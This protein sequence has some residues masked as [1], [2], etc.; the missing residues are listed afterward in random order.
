MPVAGGGF[1]LAFRP[2]LPSEDRNAA[3]SLADQ[4][5]GRRRA[6]GASYRAV[7]RDGRSPTTARS[8]GCATPRAP[9]AWTGRTPT[10]LD[11]FEKN[12]RRRPI[13]SRPPSCSRSAAPGGARPTRPIRRAWCRGMSAMAATYAHAT[14]PLRRLADRYV[15]RAAL[16]IA[17]GQA[18]PDAVTEAF[19]KLPAGDGQADALAGH[20]ERAVVDLAEAVMLARA[21]RR[22]LPARSSPTSTNAARGCS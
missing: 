11:Q 6:A 7:P 5:R 12:A 15:V 1:E 14:A 4:P 17:N 13:P 16:A 20:I 10:T 9:S 3:M 22:D 18:V 2:R 8:G 21:S 19:A